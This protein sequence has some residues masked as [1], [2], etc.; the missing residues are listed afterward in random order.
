MTEIIFFEVETA[1]FATCNFWNK[2]ISAYFGGGNMVSRR[3]NRAAKGTDSS[4]VST[5]GNRDLLVLLAFVLL[6]VG[7]LYLAAS[8]IIHFFTWA[9]DQSLSWVN[10]WRG[11]EVEAANWMGTFGAALAAIC[12]SRGFGVG[13]LVLPVIIAMLAVQVLGVAVRS[14][15]RRLLMMMVGMVIVSVCLGYLFGSTGGYLGSG[16][17]GDYGLFVSRWMVARMGFPL[18][19]VIVALVA[20][21]YLMWISSAFNRWLRARAL[22]NTAKMRRMAEQLFGDGSPQGVSSGSDTRMPEG[23]AIVENGVSTETEGCEGED[24]SATDAVEVTT[25]GVPTEYVDC[26]NLDCERGEEGD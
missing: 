14:F 13:A 24:G 4:S 11:S 9:S 25:D 18:S 15:Y 17:G 3:G 23:A 8:F 1:N 10:L 7:S 5:A 26:N 2:G 20:V 21:A 19:G 6:V 22:T 16:L 12:V